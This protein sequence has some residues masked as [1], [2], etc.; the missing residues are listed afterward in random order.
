MA[1]KGF[2]L[3]VL[4]PTDDGI[5]ISKNGIENSLYYLTYNIS[6]RSYQLSEKY[7]RRNIFTDNL[8]S[9]KELNEIILKNNIDKIVLYSDKYHDSEKVFKLKLIEI[10]QIMNYLIEYVDKQY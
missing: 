7:K 8:F 9:E 2:N 10:N 6:N 1:D 4:V 5:T 3:K